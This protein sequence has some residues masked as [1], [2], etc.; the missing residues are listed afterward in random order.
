MHSHFYQLCLCVKLGRYSAKALLSRGALKKMT[1]K[2]AEYAPIRT[3]IYYIGVSCVYTPHKKKGIT[4]SILD[5]LWC[6][7]LWGVSFL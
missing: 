5:R 3:K 7:F 2:I 1:A 6:P 4:A